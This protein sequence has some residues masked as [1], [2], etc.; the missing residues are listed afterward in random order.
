MC[1]PVAV[2][3]CLWLLLAGCASQP[4]HPA[5]QQYRALAASIS[6]DSPL[7]DY[8]RLRELHVQT[9]FYAPLGNMLSEQALFQTRQAGNWADCSAQ[10]NAILASDFTS[11][12]AHF[13]AMACAYQQQHTETGDFH[14]QVIANFLDAIWSTGDGRAPESAFVIN[15]TNELRAFI[16]LQGYTIESQSLVHQDAHSYDLM[17]INDPQSGEQQQWYFN[18]DAQWRSYGKMMD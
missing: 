15:N 10:A 2:V 5:D 12:S 6:V 4:G 14:R 17:G 9:S 1:R 18:I 7:Q 3:A 8:V 11:L 16:E 13:A